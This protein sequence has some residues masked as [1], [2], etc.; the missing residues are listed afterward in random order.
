MKRYTRWICTALFVIVVAAVIWFLQL[1]TQ[2]DVSMQYINWT[3]SVQVMPDGTEQP[4]KWESYSNAS[5][6]NGTYRFSGNLPDGL[7]A[8]SLVFETAGATISLCLNGETIY[9]SSVTQTEG[10]LSMAQA[11]IPLPEG[12]SGELVM[13]CEISDA[14]QAI[15]PPLL[16][17]MPEN[18]DI[19]ESTAIANRTAFPAGAA[20]LALVLVCGIFLLGIALKK[21]DFSLIPLLLAVIGLVSFHLIQDEGYYFLPQNV[22]NLFSHREVNLLIVLLLILYL[23]MN[24][25]R[26]FWNYLCMAA[27][28]SAAALFAC[29]LASLAGGGYLA[30]YINEGLIPQLQAGLYTGLLYWLTLWLSITAA[31]ISSYS[32]AHAFIDQKIQAQSLQIKNQMITESYQ[33][34]EERI[35]D[36]ASARHELKHQLT[37]LEC[38]IQKKDYPGIEH[39]L[40]RMTEEQDTLTQTSFT[41]NHT[42]NTILQDAAAKAKRNKTR[43]QAQINVPDDLNIPDADLCCLLMNIL[44]NALEAALKVEPSDKRYIRLHIKSADLYLAVKCENSF[45]GVIKKDKKGNLLTTKKDT[46]SHGLGFRQIKELAGKY[47]STII[48]HYTDDGVFTVQTALRIPDGPVSLSIG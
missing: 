15:F 10:T 33:A 5:E 28:C 23:A 13:T 20:A 6:I 21:T 31:L 46:L 30:F 38:L 41:G 48:Y 47:Q 9:Q 19:I 44:D 18:L 29:Y 1:F 16:R 24:R 45:D 8:G 25:R 22:V 36:G 42:L 40:T 27:A 37:A 14:A 26:Q 3:T 39:L 34:L 7:P 43:F 4:L 2:V 32:M 35:M 11:S 17:F 12:A